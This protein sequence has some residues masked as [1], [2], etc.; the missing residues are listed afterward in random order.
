LG[1][2]GDT[3]ELVMTTSVTLANIRRGAAAVAKSVAGVA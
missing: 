1:G 3:D 2:D